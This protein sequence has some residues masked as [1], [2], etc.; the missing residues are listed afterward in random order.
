MH[1]SWSDKL[2]GNK[3]RFIYLF[4]AAVVMLFTCL[5]IRDI[6]T[7]EHRWADIVYAMIYHHDY[8]HPKLNGSEYYDKPLLSYWLIIGFAKLLGSLTTWALRLPSAFAG[9]LAVWS[10]YSL[11]KSLKDRSLGLLAGW[12]L[13]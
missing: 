11:G 1:C 8:L 3:A 13:I 10:I 5:G 2:W 12:M 4:I 9:L 6:W 7:Q